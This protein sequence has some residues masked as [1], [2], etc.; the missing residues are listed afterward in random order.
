MDLPDD[1]T[2][3]AL[4]AE[5][6]NMPYGSRVRRMMTLGHLARQGDSQAQA[7]LQSLQQHTGFYE[8]LLVLLS[9]SGSED[10]EHVLNSLND[11]SRLLR[12]LATRLTSIICTDEQALAALTA[13]SPKNQVFLLR[14]LAR[15]RRHVVI[16]TFVERLAVSGDDRLT[17]FLH[18]ASEALIVRLLPTVSPRFGTTDWRRLARL[19]PRVIFEE[20][21]QRTQT[22]TETDAR[23][24]SHVN[25]IL[26]ELADNRPDDALTLVREILRHESPKRLALQRI[27]ERRPNEMIALLLAHED[28]DAAQISL[29]GL[30]YKI[31]PE[32]LQDL[33]RHRGKLLP[34]PQHWLERLSPELRRAAYDQ[35][36]LLW[37]NSEGVL[38]SAIVALLPG[39]LRVQEARRHLT[40]PALTTRPVQ[41]L[42]YATFLPW[43]EAR[44]VLLPSIQNPD[45]DLRAIALSALLG[46]A[47]FQRERLSDALAVVR[48]RANEQ[49]P[50][51]RVM[52][53]ALASL[54][55]SRWRSEHLE[56]L[57][58]IIRDGL[59]AA[60]LSP[61]TASE[62]E[63]LVV[64][65]VPFHPEW[66]AVWLGIL[67][68]S[69]G[70]ISF[71]RMGDRLTDA[72][73]ER[74]APALLPV[75]AAWETREREYYI[76]LAASSLGRR[77]RVFD[78][79]ITILERVAMN[80]RHSY[81]ANMILSMLARYRADRLATLVP[82]LLESDPSAITLPG[83]YEYL[84][85]KRQDLLTPFLGQHAYK[86]RFATGR[87]RF[88]LPLANHFYRWTPT[89]QAIFSETL[90]Q[91]TQ[92]SARDT[93][94]ILRVILQLQALP[95]I[96]PTRLIALA[97][98]EMED[99][100]VRDA[101]LRALAR[102][103]SGEGIPILVEALD[104]IRAR[105][106]IYALRS[107]ILQMPHERA[108]DL[109]RKVPTEKVTVA[110][111][112][113]RLL[114]ELETAIVFPLLLE[115]DGRTLHRDVRVALLRAF[116]DHIE[117][118]ET[119]P[120]LHRAATDPDPAV[121]AGVIRIPTDRLSSQAQQRLLDLLATLLGHADPKVRMDTLLRCTTLPVQDRRR[122]LRTP[123]LTRLASSLPDE[124]AAAAAAVFA[125]YTGSKDT[126]VVGEAIGNIQG[127]RRILASS[128]Q[129]L[130]SALAE[131][132]SRMEPTARVI[133]EVLDND[134]LTARH[135]MQLAAAGLPWED[136]VTY[137][138]R[139]ATRNEL[140]AETL[141]S[142]VRVIEAL[143]DRYGSKAGLQHLESTFASSPDERLRRLA[144]AAMVTQA[145]S[146]SGWTTALRTRL[147]TY[148]QDPSPLVAAAAQF[149][150][151]PPLEEGTSSE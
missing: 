54:P 5:L 92:D 76:A 127:N 79:L 9:C 60:D 62:I 103:D 30:V 148:Q 26:P 87:T 18:F 15:Q 113:V 99:M 32:T 120:V 104:D 140:H 58:Q 98:V 28:G 102:L 81:A 110:K 80:T 135:R 119:W 21:Y 55:P 125:T 93:P 2:A 41:R 130:H 139:M 118:D 8:R 36:G 107:A 109:L 126:A 108:L 64:A 91:I 150:F 65:L 3:D 149:T 137:L 142:A 78:A 19:H 134:P 61:A 39:D 141:M 13:A 82:A 143:T 47:R 69:R 51:R 146:L 86:G 42:P 100:A 48:A 105:I 31:P 89:Q 20:L 22:Q 83:V 71:H 128:L 63:K 132:R 94:T 59:N 23:L 131:N 44:A 85:R 14:R 45:P 121:A 50:V 77:L 16:D 12:G 116:W 136:V 112:V 106:A 115:M 56:E 88:V 84:H 95:A 147:E 29:A 129:A 122:V 151:P 25:A 90:S 67:V 73:V 66:A 46:A 72:D 1:Q 96:P 17:L 43:D 11:S 6:E 138:T 34:Q 33:L 53:A 74:I 38:D 24:R 4:I 123:L 57:G 133:L 70:T 49:D 7:M 37:R 145:I 75:L 101:A 97:D 35:L 124:S 111:E 10:G 117:R 144:L 27:T 52:I 40:L 68:K 114:G